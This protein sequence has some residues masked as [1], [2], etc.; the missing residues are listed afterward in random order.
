M[1]QISEPKNNERYRYRGLDVSWIGE[2][3]E[4][5]RKNYTAISILLAYPIE[6][7]WS[8]GF[9]PPDFKFFDPQRFVYALEHF[10]WEFHGTR[11]DGRHPKSKW[12]KTEFGKDFEII[13]TDL[14]PY[15][16]E[17][18]NDLA[19]VVLNTERRIRAFQPDAQF[20]SLTH[21]EY[22]DQ[23][24]YE[25]GWYWIATNPSFPHSCE[26]LVLRAFFETEVKPPR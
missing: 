24:L 8:P 26:T 2:D 1:L 7:S 17:P 4:I 14:Q 23:E 10:G 11:Y 18:Q 25:S 15:T 19:L 9:T 22:L 21:A 20:G 12:L 13:P 5:L 3:A 16:L 6:R